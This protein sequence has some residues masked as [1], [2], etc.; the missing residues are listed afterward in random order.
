MIQ[1]DL[2][3][4]RLQGEHRGGQGGGERCDYK[5]W[6]SEVETL[7]TAE[8]AGETKMDPVELIELQAAFGYAAEDVSMIIESMAQNGRRAHVVMGDDTPMP[9][10]SGRPH[11][12]YDYFKQRFAQVTN[13]AIDPLRE[14]FVMSLEMTIGAKGNLLQQRRRQGHPRR[15]HQVPVLFDEDV[16]AV[17]ATRRGSTRTASLL[18]RRRR[19]RRGRAPT[20]R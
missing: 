6:L 17:M 19:L 3:D 2:D 15:A 4:G 13:P 11:L 7:P 18:L 16:D 10:L 5:S 14:G 8:P 20:P 9:V 12:L 1:A